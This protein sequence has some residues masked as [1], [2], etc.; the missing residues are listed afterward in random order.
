M[1]L[2]IFVKL[3]IMFAILK[4]FFFPSELSQYD[5][6]EQKTEAVIHNLTERAIETAPPP[7][8]SN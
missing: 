8:H 4:V 2:I 3:F 6:D 1:W 7:L 5:N